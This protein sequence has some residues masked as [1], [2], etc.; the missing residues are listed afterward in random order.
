M[1]EDE[2]RVTP[3]KRAFHAEF[4]ASMELET[5]LNKTRK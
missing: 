2:I 3:E 5:C 1:T 4:Y